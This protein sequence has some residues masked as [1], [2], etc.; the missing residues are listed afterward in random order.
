ML[1]KVLLTTNKVLLVFFTLAIGYSYLVSPPENVMRGIGQL[2]PLAVIGLTV[3]AATRS[4][5]RMANAALVGNAV[6]S[7]LALVAAI[8]AASTMSLAVGMGTIVP[9]ILFFVN[10]Y[11]LFRKRQAPSAL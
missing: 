4:T 5:N 1:P 6:I 9:F 10:S 11:Y 7:L 2:I 8:F 3:V